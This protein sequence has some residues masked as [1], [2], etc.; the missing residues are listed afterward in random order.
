[1]ELNA[2]MTEAKAV[3][4]NRRTGAYIGEH[5]GWVRSPALARLFDNG[6]HALH[7]CVDEELSAVDILTREENTEVHFLRF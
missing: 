4:K 7:F 5:N 2:V 1:M 6:Y 3:V